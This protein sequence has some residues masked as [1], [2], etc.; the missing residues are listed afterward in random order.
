MTQI[1]RQMIKFCMVVILGGLFL[2][3]APPVTHA[4]APE[5]SAIRIGHNNNKTRFVLDINHNV[6]FNIFTLA[7]PNRIVIDI[8]EV[9]WKSNFGG[10]KGK[11]YIDRYRYGLFKPGTSRIVLDVKSPVTVHKAFIIKP[12]GNKPYRFVIDLKKISK[13]AFQDR[14]KKPIP[15]TARKKNRLVLNKT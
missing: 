10:A 2:Q 15:R 4:K 14:V 6:K 7:N 5:V 8:S 11:G 3:I 1:I 12:K 9:E 13:K